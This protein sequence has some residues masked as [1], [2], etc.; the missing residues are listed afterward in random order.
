MDNSFST[1]VPRPT[2][3]EIDLR[4]LTSNFQKVQEHVGI[5][6]RII[7][8]IKANAYGHGAKEIACQLKELRAPHL[9]VAILEE[10][11]ELRS[12]GIE[13][14]IL[15]LNGYWPGQEE[16]VVRHGLTPAVVDLE[17]VKALGRVAERMQKKA[18]YHLKIN[19]GM[20]RL[21][22]DWEQ[23]KFLME[24][25]LQSSWVH[26]QG[27]LTHLS[28]ADEME[29]PET[30]RQLER[31]NK[32]VQDLR[33]RG[34][35]QGWIHAANSAAVLRWP[36]SWY[37][38]VRPGLIL[39]G[40]NPFNQG[41]IPLQPL[42]SLK[43]RLMNLRP[44]KK[45]TSVG[46]GCSYTALRDSVI[47]ALPIGYADG[48]NRLLSNRASVLLHGQRVPVVGRVSMDLTV[49]DVT[50]VPSAQLGDEV[51]LIGSQG[52]EQIRANELAE[53]CHTIPYEILTGI[54]QRVPRVFLKTQ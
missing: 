50:D 6:T 9:A 16:E 33:S 23:V 25:S 26:C 7:A 30:S 35:R 52:S 4:A 10:A 34:I 49:I 47:G 41:P 45:G 46:Y 28:S 51:V 22:V 39:Y 17:R 44:I 12:A 32:V 27:I 36:A 3:A 15:L 42:L 24:L 37:D 2:W 19:T 5:G 11:L 29:S 53:L 21:G 18:Y 20:S 54:S 1:G 31:F 8:V 48:Y 38:A 40:V 14:P 13:L 43:T